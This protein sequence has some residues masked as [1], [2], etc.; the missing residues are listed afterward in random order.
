M[1]LVSMSSSTAPGPC[2]GEGMRGREHHRWMPTLCTAT[3]P[4]GRGSA[5][6][7]CHALAAM[8]HTHT[9]AGLSLRAAAQSLPVRRQQMPLPER[10]LPREPLCTLHAPVCS[11]LAFS[12]SFGGIALPDAMCRLCSAG[13]PL[14]MPRT[15]R[16]WFISLP[17]RPH[18]LVQKAEQEL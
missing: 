4:I 5:G 17:M 14:L 15:A 8:A 3:G 12:L 9:A 11:R 1:L 7:A 16:L 18:A 10:A 13:P 2:K 6:S